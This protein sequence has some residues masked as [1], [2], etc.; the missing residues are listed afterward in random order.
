MPWLQQQLEQRG[1]EVFQP[2]MPDTDTPVISAW[3]NH[4]KEVVGTPDQDAYFVAGSIGCQALLRY[5]E[6]LPE[7]VKVLSKKTA[8]FTRKLP[9]GYYFFN[10]NE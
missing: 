3:I 7:G 2:E 8:S 6:I 10:E 5:L 4:L 9:Y 1:F